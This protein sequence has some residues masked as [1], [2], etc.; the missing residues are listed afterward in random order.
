MAETESSHPPKP[1]LALRVGVT[2][3]RR[4]VARMPEGA[5]K[6]ALADPP[7]LAPERQAK[8]RADVAAA[9]RR[10]ADRLHALEN[11]SGFRDYYADGPAIL[12]LISPLALGADRIVAQA[13][14]EA[15][16]ELYAP[17]P[18]AKATYATDFPEDDAEFDEL[19]EHG[20]VF[21]LDGSR[22]QEEESYREVGRFVVRNSDLV[23]AIWDGGAVKKVGGTAE[24]A[25]FALQSRVPVLWI[26]AYG[27]AAPRLLLSPAELRKAIHPRDEKEAPPEEKWDVALGARLDRILLPPRDKRILE[28]LKL[29]LEEVVST[30]TGIWRRLTFFKASYAAMLSLFAAGSRRF[31]SF[32]QQPKG[33]WRPYASC[34]DKLAIDYADAYRNTY[35]W[36][37]IFA[38]LALTA[39]AF[40]RFLPAQ[41]EAASYV[42]A[43]SLLAILLLFWRSTTQNF[44]EKWI[45]YRLLAE[46][47]RQQFVI[48]LT[49][50]SIPV[51]ECE[52][53]TRRTQNDAERETEPPF[54][55]W[56]AWY[57]SAAQRAALLPQGKISKRNEK[58]LRI[59]KSLVEEQLGYHRNRLERQQTAGERIGASARACFEITLT[60]VL[61]SLLANTLHVKFIES[62]K[63]HMEFGVG[64]FSALSAALLGVRV[65]AEF[66][67]LTR[68]SQLML[69]ALEEAERE[70]DSIDP[71]APLASRDLGRVLFALALAMLQDLKGWSQLYGVKHIEPG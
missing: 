42:E 50:R 20:V 6:E 58:A 65:Y 38:F 46:L 47:T 43:A 57:F 29:Y 17:L 26:D 7:D 33:R 69:R 55:A 31:P 11:K 53:M 52:S 2:G 25:R 44:H 32:G 16:Y 4:L 35:V 23:V 14:I 22:A 18:F 63:E 36:I 70:L 28:R 51:S 59:G 71:A 64:L 10:V 62:F 8:I 9:L 49:G 13:A 67:L 30:E 45:A 27:E 5:S 1:R 39:P 60:L 40:G 48:S 66:F 19:L 24:I 21:E 68:Q 15:C 37:A 61:A 56:T 12:R 34:A 3:A 41:R 54:E